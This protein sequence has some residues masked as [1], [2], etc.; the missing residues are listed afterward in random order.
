MS[1]QKHSNIKIGIT[2]KRDIASDMHVREEI[3]K[4]ISAILKKEKANSFVAY[5]AMAKGADTIFADVVSS[6][7][8]QPLKIVLPFDS[9]EYE[10]DFTEAQ[11]LSVYKNWIRKIGINEVTTKDIPK[12]KDQRN[13]AYF[14]VG[15]FLVDHCDYMIVVWDELKPRGKGGTAEILG[16]AK[17]QNKSVEIIPVQPKRTDEIDSKINSLLK[18]SDDNAV[19]LKTKYERIWVVSLIFGWLTALS[20]DATLSFHF[21]TFGKIMFAVAELAFIITVYLLIRYTKAIQLHPKLLNERLR[22]EKLRLLISYYH[23]DMPITISEITQKD[24]KELASIG[25]IVNEAINKSYQSKLYKHFAI[26]NLIDGQINYHEKLAYERIGKIPERLERAKWVI[27]VAWF[28]ILISHL[29]ALLFQYFDWNNV[30]ILSYYAYPEEISRFLA[31]GLPATYAGIE[32][33]LYFK[34]WENFKKQSISMIKFLNEEKEQLHKSELNNEKMLSTLNSVS[35][36]MLADNRNWNSILS[37]KVAPH[38][39]L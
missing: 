37:K 12:N 1:N 14:S 35:S 15:I 9:A 38:P 36:A 3:K 18:S 33:F 16:Y 27:Y 26:K 34:E 21:S 7:F 8:K 6:D 5:S 28:M 17:E 20:F 29:V 25:E 39:I 31:I 30:P 4:K 32:G 23:A 2:G 22:A 10:K 19:K 24:D 11:D 13:E